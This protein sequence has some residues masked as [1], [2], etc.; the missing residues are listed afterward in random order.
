MNQIFTFTFT[1][2]Q[3]NEMVACMNNGPFGQV[4]KVLNELRRQMEPQNK[5]EVISPSPP[6]GNG[7]ASLTR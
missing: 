2:E 1:L 4:S 7:E 5:P 6:P 3:V